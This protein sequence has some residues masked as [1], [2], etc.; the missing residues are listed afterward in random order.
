LLYTNIGNNQK[1]A[2]TLVFL[3]KYQASLEAAKRAN[4]P[5]VWKE[6]VFACVRSKEFRLAAIADLNIVI[7]P[8]NFDDLIQYYERFGYYKECIQLLESRL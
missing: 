8:D 3:K 7:H 2:S 6:V 4:I 5:K 1:L